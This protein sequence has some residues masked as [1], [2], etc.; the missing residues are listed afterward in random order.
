MGG[1]HPRYLYVYRSIYS[2]G[3]KAQSRMVGFVRG[4]DGQWERF[5]EYRTPTFFP[6][7]QVVELLDETGWKLV[8][9]TNTANLHEPVEDPESLERVFFIAQRS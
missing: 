5:D 1:R 9:V 3:D 6:T 2:G 4:E 8:R 7:R